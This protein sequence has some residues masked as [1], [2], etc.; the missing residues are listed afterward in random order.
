MEVARNWQQ[1]S[2]SSLSDFRFLAAATYSIQVLDEES[3]TKEPYL[4]R[5][6]EELP[7][8]TLPSRE[9]MQ[10]QCSIVSKVWVM[11]KRTQITLRL[12][13]RSQ[14]PQGLEYSE[15]TLP[16]NKKQDLWS[17]G[18]KSACQFRGHWFNPWSGKIPPVSGQPSPCT[19]TIEPTA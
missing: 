9:A 7:V 11:N 3:I 14:G 5:K 6:V 1:N 4:T 10:K 17:N 8:H 13:S 2:S 18:Y 19:T 12:Q 16:I 15:S